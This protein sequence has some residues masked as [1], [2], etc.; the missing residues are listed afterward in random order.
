[1]GA[2]AVAMPSCYPGAARRATAASRPDRALCPQIDVCSQG[3]TVEEARANLREALE[4]F[5]EPAP[6]EEVSR[7]LTNEAYVTQLDIAG[8]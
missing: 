6:P 7:R 5:L 3:E 8:G 1:M 2:L 4:L